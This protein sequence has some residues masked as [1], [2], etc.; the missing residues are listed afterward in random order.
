M[1]K[2]FQFNFCNYLFSPVY[3]GITQDVFSYENRYV[4]NKKQSNY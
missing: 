4:K 3:C 2:K 1:I